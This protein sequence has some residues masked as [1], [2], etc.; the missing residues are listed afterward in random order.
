MH[1]DQ[2]AQ[3]QAAEEA[4]GRMD[5]GRQ[6]WKQILIGPDICQCLIEHHPKCPSLDASPQSSR[7]GVPRVVENQ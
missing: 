2:G 6:R 5:G 1:S 7:P 4:A 3:W